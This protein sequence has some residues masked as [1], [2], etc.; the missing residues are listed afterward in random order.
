MRL[1]GRQARRHLRRVLRMAGLAGQLEGLRH[2]QAGLMHGHAQ[3]L[4]Q[5]HSSI[6]TPSLAARYTSLHQI[7]M[8][9]AVDSE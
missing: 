1:L 6:I 3:Q 9:L 7:R 2:R 8:C 5:Q 4:R